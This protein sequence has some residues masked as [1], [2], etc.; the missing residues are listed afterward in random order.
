VTPSRDSPRSV[1]LLLVA[2][3]HLGL[4]YPLRPRIERRRR[5]DD[6]FANLEASLA[7]ALAGEVDIVVHGG[8]LLD[9]P[10]VPAD[11][12]YLALAPLLRVAS[13]GVPVYL[14]PGNHERS[15]IPYP[16]L[17]RHENLHIFDR[18]R[19][20]VREF[21]GVSVALA[22]FPFRRQV[23]D[24]FVDLVAETGHRR[25]HADVRL[26]CLHQTVEGAR[27]GPADY[28]FRG[29]PEVVRGRDLPAGFA[30][31]L[32]GHIHRA[33]KL[34][35][36]LRGR[37]FPAPVLYPGSVERTAFAE[38]AEDKGFLRLELVSAPVTGGRL[39]AA[40]FVRLPAR[41]MVSLELAVGSLDP[42]GLR[43]RLTDE[44]AGL[45]PDAVV[46]IRIRG[47][48]PQAALPILAAPALRALAPATMN[49]TLSYDRPVD[50]R[51]RGSAA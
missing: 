36:D 7:P 41:P 35:H 15:R 45:D 5:G 38:R 18:P 50:R 30:A 22:G 39:A 46:R 34:T 23:R 32:S 25:Q 51:R 21:A 47:S 27:V 1:R 29:G 16:L 19:T 40:T 37:P 14:V 28:T 9:R 48:I 43:Q 4:D 17:S 8:D 24:Q 10:R 49:V 42:A 12:A 6:F 33:Q 2:D 11:L 44:L 26:L 3:T 31:I 13:A 20:F